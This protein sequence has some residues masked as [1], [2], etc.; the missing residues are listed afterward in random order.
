MALTKVHNRMISGA[1][2]NV[3]DYGADLTGTA[4]STPAVQAAI[5]AAHTAGGGVVVVPSGTVKLTVQ[6]T[7]ASIGGT[8]PNSYMLNFKDKSQVAMRFEGDVVADHGS[9]RADVFYLDTTTD[10]SFTGLNLTLNGTASICDVFQMYNTTR[11][12]IRNCEVVGGTGTVEAFVSAE[13]SNEDFIFDSNKLTDA[14]DWTAG[15]AFYDIA[16][17][18]R[19]TNNIF[20][21][22]TQYYAVDLERRDASS[23]GIFI[24]GN[25]FKDVVYTAIKTA[26]DE[27]II[28]DNVIEGVTASGSQAGNPV[29]GIISLDTQFTV[30]ANNVVRDADENGIRIARGNRVVVSGNITE[31][32]GNYGLFFD[33]T[34]SGGTISNVTIAASNTFSEANAVGY[35][36]Y[37]K[38]LNIRDLRSE[39]NNLLCNVGHLIDFGGIQN[40]LF[41]IVGTWARAANDFA[42]G[43]TALKYAANAVSGSDRI[44]FSLPSELYS[45]YKGK[46]LKLTLNYNMANAAYVGNARIRVQDGVNDYNITLPVQT[47]PDDFTV[48][49]GLDASATQCV[50]TIYGQFSATTSHDLFLNYFTIGC[51]YQVSN[52]TLYAT[53]T[54]TI[55]LVDGAEATDPTATTSPF[56]FIQTSGTWRTLV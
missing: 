20:N 10:C 55:T 13:T 43:N 31:G 36:R 28:T 42:F 12:I 3:I 5:N 7:I 23:T 29:D 35:T 44:S 33:P 49:V 56:K 41:T 21:G 22:G 48:T 47:D 46:D 19:I 11:I 40:P 8:G 24:S 26:C 9:T 51:S 39:A 27:S 53:A 17:N 6:G 25:Y 45:A 15:V 37:D 4:D 14:V 2:F 18:I 54:P 32:N 52:Q 1:E 34:S 30:I 50:I 38:L 16:K